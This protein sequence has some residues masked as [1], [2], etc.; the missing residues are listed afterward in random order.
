MGTC[1]RYG[2]VRDRDVFVM[3]MRVCAT[4]GVME[5]CA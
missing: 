1:L 4:G 3:G 2:S 5:M